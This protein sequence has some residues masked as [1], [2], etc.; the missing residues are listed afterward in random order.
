MPDAPAPLKTT[1]IWSMLLARQLHRIQQRRAGDDRRA[2]LIVVEDG[3][4]HRLLQRLF[5]VEALRRLDVFQVDAAEG[6]LEQLAGLDDLVGILGV[7]LDIEHID[8]GEAFEQ[9]AFAFHHRLAGQRAD[10]AESEHR[11]AVGDHGDQVAFGGV[12]EGVLRILLDFEAGIGYARGV[13]EA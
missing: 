3:N 13:G 4:L 6:G 8:V 10:V 9:D 12:L 5:D 1:L 7:E 11:G 2:V